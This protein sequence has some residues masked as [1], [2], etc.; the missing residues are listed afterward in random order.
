M[1]IT[2]DEISKEEDELRLILIEIHDGLCP[3][4]KENIIYRFDWEWG[5]EFNTQKRVYSCPKCGFVAK[6]IHKW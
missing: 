6:E 5:I 1:V 3:I 2:L 4:C